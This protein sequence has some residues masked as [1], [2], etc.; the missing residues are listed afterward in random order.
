MRNPLYRRDKCFIRQSMLVVQMSSW[1]SF[2]HLV[3]YTLLM[4]WVNKLTIGDLFK[5][6]CNVFHVFTIKM[7]TSAHLNEFGILW[8]Q[9]RISF[10]CFIIKCLLGNLLVTWSTTLCWWIEWINWLLVICLEFAAMYLPL[11]WQLQLIW[12]NLVFFWHRTEFHLFVS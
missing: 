2:S 5:V 10:I 3:N 11:K 4:D 7:R 12:M 1:E 8:T 9:N 6:C